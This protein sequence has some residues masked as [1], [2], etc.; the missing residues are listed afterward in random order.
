MP[1]PTHV[2]VSS[3]S[4]LTILNGYRLSRKFGAHLLFEIRDIWP[5]SII[6]GSSLTHQNIFVSFL[7]WVEKFGYNKADVVVGTMPNLV[8]HVHSVC[9]DQIMVRTIGLGLDPDL[10]KISSVGTA[11]PNSQT[12]R[13]AYAGSIG[14]ANA[15]DKL[16]EVAASFNPDDGIIFEF[17][18]RGDYLDK[19]VTRYGSL[20]HIIFHGAIPRNELLNEILSIDAVFLAAEDSEIWRYGQ[21]LHKV[22]EYMALGR[23]IIAAYS[24]FPLMIDQAECGI[25]VPSDDS[26]ALREAILKMKSMTAQQRDEMGAKGR[27][28]V[29]QNLPYSKL[30]R[31]Y[32]AV[33]DEL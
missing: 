3:L 1:R 20:S 26:P 32:L 15:L 30:A 25:L 17:F 5:L 27:T 12:F 18:G 11:T 14:R 4:L 31:E 13:V 33:M 28:W 7:S 29:L 6:I 23:P 24:G 10:A 2:I 16:L 22:V 19:F 9:N 21:S 8:E